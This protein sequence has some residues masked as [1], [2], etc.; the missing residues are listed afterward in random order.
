MLFRMFEGELQIILDRR[1]N[2]DDNRGLGEP[3]RD[4]KITRSQFYILVEKGDDLGQVLVTVLYLLG[5]DQ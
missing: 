3:L 1:L 2:Q 5:K 4:N